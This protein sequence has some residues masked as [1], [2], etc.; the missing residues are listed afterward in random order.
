LLTKSQVSKIEKHKASNTGVEIKLSV[1]Q[2]KRNQT[3]GWLPILPILAKVA[4]PIAMSAITG[5]VGSLANTLADKIAG[6]GI[7][8]EQDVSL[9]L[10]KNDLNELVKIAEVLER[11]SVLPSG[12][13][14]AISRQ[15]DQKG[16]AFLL[17]LVASLIG[18]LGSKKGNGIYLPWEKN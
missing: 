2:L 3:G 9:S 13:S 11:K 1:S 7:Q 10:S 16:G 12:S 17:P 5:L 4:A 8:D 18:T 14:V 15:A 6:K